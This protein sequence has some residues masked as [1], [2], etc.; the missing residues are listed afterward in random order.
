VASV[1]IVFLG[2]GLQRGSQTITQYESQALCRWKVHGESIAHGIPIS[3]AMK[4]EGDRPSS[5]L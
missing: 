4:Q 1:F 3:L 5:V 2:Q